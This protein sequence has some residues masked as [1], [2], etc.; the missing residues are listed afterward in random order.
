MSQGAGP[1]ISSV[2]RAWLCPEAEAA[3]RDHLWR[4]LRCKFDP[5]VRKI[6]LEKEMAT[7]TSMLGWEN[8]MD[9][10]AWQATIHGMTES[11]TPEPA[12]HVTPTL[13]LDSPNALPSLSC[14]DY[15]CIPNTHIF[16]IAHHNLTDHS[17]RSPDDSSI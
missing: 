7:Y 13:D 9:R 5:G 4:R 11:D 14:S 2:L 1:G 10:G 8:P 6:P 15:S 16:L 3:P 17:W 12:C